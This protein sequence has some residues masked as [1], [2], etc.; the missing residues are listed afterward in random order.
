MAV[1]VWKEKRLKSRL[2][3]E[4]K[5]FFIDLRLKYLKFKIVPVSVQEVY[6]NLF[7]VLFQIECQN[8]NDDLN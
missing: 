5:F 6:I 3:D 4:I 2:R 1:V 8:H 7:N